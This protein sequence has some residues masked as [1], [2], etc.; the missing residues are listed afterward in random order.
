VTDTTAPDFTLRD[1]AG[2]P[3]TLSAHR[4]H[5]VVLIFLRGDW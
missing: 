3:W 4:G 2:D 1:Q 5:A